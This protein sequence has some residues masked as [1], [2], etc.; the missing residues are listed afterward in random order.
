MR[1]T[2]KRRFMG[3]QRAVRRV[4]NAT[5]EKNRAI[6]RAYARYLATQAF[7]FTSAF[8]RPITGGAKALFCSDSID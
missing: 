8:I 6:L 2:K 7:P 4:S 5:T 3:D 1:K